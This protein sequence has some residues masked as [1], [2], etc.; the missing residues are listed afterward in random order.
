MSWRNYY[1]FNSKRRGKRSAYKSIRGRYRFTRDAFRASGR[2]AR[3]ALGL[4]KYVKSLVN[5]EFKYHD[6]G[7]TGSL[8]TTPS[9]TYITQ[10]AQGDSSST[11]DGNSVKLKSLDL[12]AKFTGNT[13]AEATYCRFIVG[14][15]KL[16][17][18]TNVTVAG[19]TD[20]SL[21]GVQDPC[22]Q[23]DLNNKKRFIILMDK[24]VHFSNNSQETRYFKLFKNFNMKMEYN[25]TGASDM[26]SNHLFVM[27]FSDQATNTPTWQYRSRVRFL[28]N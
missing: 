12:R 28:D 3:K 11:R 1:G 15:D 24:V 22:S 19:A 25:G 21:L 26:R 6:A 17:S 23:R 10:I 8:S 9:I 13:S 18:G 4:A 7:V 27:A 2:T 16:H 20:N 14:I 5:V